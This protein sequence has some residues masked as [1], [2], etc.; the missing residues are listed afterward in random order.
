MMPSLISLARIVS[1]GHLAD[2]V[3]VRRG[4]L[5]RDKYGKRRGRIVEAD[6]R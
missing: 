2:G 3:F 6:R 4:H 1:R 5:Y